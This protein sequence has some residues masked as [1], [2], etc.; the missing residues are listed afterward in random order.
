MFKCKACNSS[1]SKYTLTTYK[2]NGGIEDLCQKCIYVVD[3][4]DKLSCKD[5][6]HQHITDNWLGFSFYDENS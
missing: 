2:P 4:T 5:Y 3:N 1:L 6:A